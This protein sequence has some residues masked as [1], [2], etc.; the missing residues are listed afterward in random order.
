MRPPASGARGMARLGPAGD[1]KLG[2]AM[3]RGA[4]IVARHARIGSAEAEAKLDAFLDGPVDDYRTAR[5]FPAG[6]AT[7]RLSENLTLGE[8]GPRRI[9]WRT[10][11]APGTGARATR[12]PSISLKELAWRDF[13]HHLIYHTP[14]ILDRQLAAGM[15][16]D[17][18]GG[19]QRGRRALAA[20]PDRRALRRCRDA[21]DVC[22]RHHAQPRP[23]DRGKYL[24]K[25]LMTH[26]R[27]GCDGSPT[28]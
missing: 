23:D 1:W 8:I 4:G 3:N 16:L 19:R 14:G 25:H 13:A 7:S 22:H 17:F 11:R 5:D 26:W 24:T 28:A 15:G 20:R 2:A 18:P 9:W 21:R 6:E 12:G 27:S 10:Q